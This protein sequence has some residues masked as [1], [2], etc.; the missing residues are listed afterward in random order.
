LYLKE[1]KDEQAEKEFNEAL[2]HNP[3][4]PGSL[5]GLAK[6]HVRQDKYQQALPEIDRAVRLAP[7]SQN[8]HFLRGRILMKLGRREAAQ[9]EMAAAKKL[10]DTSHDKEKEPGA[11]DED[12]VRNPELAQPPQ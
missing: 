6:I 2:R 12:R 9:K 8:V 10:I 1:G 7:E 3:R 11:M 5:F 4:M